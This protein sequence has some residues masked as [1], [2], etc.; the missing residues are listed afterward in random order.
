MC[1]DPHYAVARQLLELGEA[2]ARLRQE[3]GWTRGK[4]GRRLR[5]KAGDIEI[6]EEDTPRA[7]AGL[8]EEALGLLVNE[9]A[10]KMRKRADVGLSISRIRHLRPALVAF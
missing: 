10:P 2:I 6:L 7:A 3:A 9:I 5:V 4:L 8:L 1:T